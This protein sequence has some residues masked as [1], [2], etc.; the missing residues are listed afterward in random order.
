MHPTPSIPYA[1]PY[2]EPVA[3]S[4]ADPTPTIARVREMRGDDEIS[5]DG[6]DT[7]SAVALL[8]RLLEA[9]GLSAARLSASDRDALLAALHRRVWGDR[10]VAE[11]R[12]S[13]CEAMYDLSFEL[14]GLQR[15]LVGVVPPHRVTEPNRLELADGRGFQLP[16]ATEEQD[17]AAYGLEA[18]RRQLLRAAFGDSPD[19]PDTVA[20][21]ESLA[22]VLDVDLNAACAECGQVQR[23]RFDL[24]SFVLQRVLDDRPNLLA[25]LHAIA[26]GYG[27]SLTEI[28]SLPRSLRRS[29]TDRLVDSTAA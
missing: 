22:P 21:I 17:A 19:D 8:D 28:L 15:H 2:A 18:G 26:S 20:L 11:L 29:L 23:V 7:R 10:I 9:P 13:A 24:Q 16:S 6:V 27:W 4:H 3:V 12:C 25:D 5:V 14:S 1:V